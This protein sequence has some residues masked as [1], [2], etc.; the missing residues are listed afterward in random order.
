MRREVYLRVRGGAPLAVVHGRE[1]R[2]GEEAHGNH[3]GDE[4]MERRHQLDSPQWGSCLN[5]LAPRLLVSLCEIVFAR[6]PSPFKLGS[7][8]IVPVLAPA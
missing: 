2:D 7:E 6:L 3:V 4:A 8:R 5:G 1:V